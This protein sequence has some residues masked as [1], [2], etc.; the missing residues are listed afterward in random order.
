MVKNNIVALRNGF[1]PSWLPCFPLRIC[2]P[3]SIASLR[4]QAYDR[5]RSC[6][7]A[8]YIM[9]APRNDGHP[10]ITTL[11]KHKGV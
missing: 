4:M 6:F 5:Q 7:T 8:E 3:V 9:F 1:Q 10:R 11:L 2:I